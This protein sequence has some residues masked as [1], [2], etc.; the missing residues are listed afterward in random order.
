MDNEFVDYRWRR[1]FLPRLFHRIE[2]VPMRLYSTVETICNRFG[3]REG[4]I[5]SVS[6]VEV[7]MGNIFKLLCFFRAD[8]ESCAA[9]ASPERFYLR[10]ALRV[11]EI[12][13]IDPG[14][15][16][17]TQSHSKDSGEKCALCETVRGTQSLRGLRAP[18][19]RHYSFRALNSL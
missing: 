8:M 18:S 11:A 17:V 12:C 5:R 10:T 14:G 6:V 4:Y 9:A 13:Q 19:D 1:A 16:R 2:L 3:V 7:L 15:L